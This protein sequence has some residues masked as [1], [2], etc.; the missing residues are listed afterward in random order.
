MIELLKQ[1]KDIK[2][3]TGM[4]KFLKNNLI[5]DIK[6][7]KSRRHY[8]VTIGDHKNNIFIKI[9]LDYIYPKIDAIIR[10][11]NGKNYDLYQQVSNNVKHHGRQNLCDYLDR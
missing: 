11:H 6:C 5:C 3:F 7:I 4:Q 1:I 9:E 8:Y 2:T 10:S